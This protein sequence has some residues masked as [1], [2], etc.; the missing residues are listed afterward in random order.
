[1]ANI[2]ISELTP[3]AAASGTQEFEVNDSLT[4]KKVT[5]AQVLSY[6][7]ANT[8]VA[9]VDG[10]QT[11]LDGKLSTANGAVGEANLANNAVTEVKINNNAV[12]TDK[13]NNGAVTVPKIGATG[14]PGAGNFLRGDGSWQTISTT[15]TTQQVLDAYAGVSAGAVGAYTVALWPSVGASG[16][17]ISIGSTIAGSSLLRLPT[18][19]SIGS[20][21][22]VSTGESAELSGTWRVMMRLRNN[23]SDT[24][25]VG[26]IFVRIS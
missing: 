7:H 12:T 4:S 25:N 1:M 24:R 11:A 16:G 2:K 22:R 20:Y 13:I 6:V 15:P 14:T 19:E 3:A 8:G 23:F 26:G 21:I 17:T 9:N 10:L 5:G 18:D